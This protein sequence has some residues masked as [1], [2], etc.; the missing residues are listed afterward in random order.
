MARH[1]ED[2]KPIGT[3]LTI[4]GSCGETGVGGS[5][6]TV[7]NVDT[8][9][10]IV[11]LLV[12]FGFKPAECDRT[13]DAV[14]T[15]LLKH[16][17]TDKKKSQEPIDGILITHTHFD[18]LQA[19]LDVIAAQYADG[20]RIKSPTIYASPYGA[21]FMEGKMSQSGIPS[22][23][24][25]KVVAVEP[26]DKIVF[27]DGND[28]TVVKAKDIQNGRFPVD[29]GH[30]FVTPIAFS[31]TAHNSLGYHVLSKVMGN[32]E[33]GII[34]TGDGTMREA[35]V[36]HSF[37]K[38]AYQDLLENEFVTH[39]ISDSTSNA[40]NTP[41]IS[42]EEK[43]ASYKT[44]MEDNE[45]SRIVTSVISGSLE[46]AAPIFEAAMQSGRKVFIDAPGLSFSARIAELRGDLKKYKDVIV[47]GTREEFEKSVP[48]NKRVVILSGP[49]ADGAGDYVKEGAGKS[50]LVVYSESEEDKSRDVV[51]VSQKCV[52]G[53][54]VEDENGEKVHTPGIN[55]N[56]M[57][58]VYNQIARSGAKIYENPSDIRM[59]S[60]SVILPFQPSGHM[61]KEEYTEFLSQHKDKN[62]VVISAHGDTG[63]RQKGQAVAEELG[64]NTVFVENGDVLRLEQGETEKT[65]KINYGLIGTRQEKIAGQPFGR[66]L[67]L[68]RV[69]AIQYPDEYG[70]TVEIYNMLSPFA[71]KEI[72][73][74]KGR[75]TQAEAERFGKEADKAQSRGFFKKF[76]KGRN[77]F[78]L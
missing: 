31:H 43:V 23:Y 28:G 2:R 30:V 20:S 35:M 68:D 41:V 32:N 50:G 44:V 51:I 55:Q 69:E 58:R 57:K 29:G 66:T 48:F 19:L 63:Q 7:T 46:N 13:Y 5:S 1:F 75:A 73:I 25:P 10:D 74:Q 38:E 37:D 77:D 39:L 65:D 11:R 34:F 59:V 45:D 53:V 70:Q 26:G 22:E 47:G 17:D 12:D 61:N 60:N 3:T 54:W 71:S 64:F 14:F 78:S 8:D 27:G 67:V 15:D 33:A 4:N 42:N 16:F 36:G 76:G 9:Q 21:L 52:G 6:Y 40:S 24:R 18:H 72:R 62:I 49:F 56:G